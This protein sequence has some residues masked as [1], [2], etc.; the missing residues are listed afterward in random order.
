MN[1]YIKTYF[2]LDVYTVIFLLILGLTE[3][4]T[5][6]ESIPCTYRQ[7]YSSSDYAVYM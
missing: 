3:S 4:R 2:V 6:P 1:V 7:Q 5:C